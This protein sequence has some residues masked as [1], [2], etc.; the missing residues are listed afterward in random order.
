MTQ[1]KFPPN[2]YSTPG[3]YTVTLTV[4][5]DDGA[6]GT[7]TETIIVSD[8]SSEDCT[9][10][11]NLAINGVASQSTLYS[12]GVASYANDGNLTGD[13]PHGAT[14]N[15]QHTADNEPEPWWEVDLGQ[16]SDVQSITI[17]NRTTSSSF[18]LGRLNNFWVFVSAH[19]L[20]EACKVLKITQAWRSSSSLEMQDLLKIST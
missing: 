14:A 5:D 18:L 1:G 19:P 2:T 13:S 16:Q 6:T 15:L 11:I 12:N 20:A 7:A 17:Y 10:P 3:T 8:P 9:D 4:T